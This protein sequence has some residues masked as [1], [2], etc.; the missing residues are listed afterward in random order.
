MSSFAIA[1]TIMPGSLAADGEF[2]L[3]PLLDT[4]ALFVSSVFVKTS[5]GSKTRG[6]HAFLNH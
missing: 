3:L 5:L 6:S 1:T 2:V 4:T